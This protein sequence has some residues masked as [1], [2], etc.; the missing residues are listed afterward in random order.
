MLE[1][2]KLRVYELSVRGCGEDLNTQKYQWHMS[3]KKE[4]MGYIDA[5]ALL[6]ERSD[7]QRLVNSN[8]HPADQDNY[9]IL[10][11][12]P[13]FADPDDALP[14]SIR[15]HAFHTDM[16]PAATTTERYASSL[17]A[18]VGEDHASPSM[19]KAAA[20][21]PAV[22]QP[23]LPTGRSNSPPNRRRV[24]LEGAQGRNSTPSRSLQR[25]QVKIEEV[26]SIDPFLDPKVILEEAL[27]QALSIHYPKEVVAN[28]RKRTNYSS[29]SAEEE[30]VAREM[31]KRRRASL[32]CKNEKI[33]RATLNALMD[34][35]RKELCL[36]QE[37]IDQA[38]ILSNALAFIRIQTQAGAKMSTMHLSRAS[39]RKRK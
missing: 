34:E 14:T 35:I 13:L 4:D 17:V 28:K 18:Q 1:P 22:T 8:C 30:K 36:P 21:S 26:P 10:V 37:G 27:K 25:P 15:E 16:L 6:D 11:H 2:L 20:G 23:F 38:N 5:N 31:S 3:S 12:P 9:D 19:A 7:N 33:R 32:K 29:M 39:G 24:K